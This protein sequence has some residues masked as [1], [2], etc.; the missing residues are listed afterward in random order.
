MRLNEF[1][2]GNKE[3]A[4]TQRLTAST[5]KILAAHIQR[6]QGGGIDVKNPTIFATQIGAWATKFFNSPD[7]VKANGITL[8]NVKPYVQRLVS[9]KLAGLNLNTGQPYPATHPV[10]AVN[11][12]QP[13]QP[14]PANPQNTPNQPTPSVAPVGT[15][16]K[17]NGGN[18]KKTIT[19]WISELGVKIVSP[20]GIKK[21]EEIAEL[22]AAALP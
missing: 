10:S 6:L 9:R 8:N 20:S 21:L 5:L 18:Y 12:A 16:V 19:G 15:V 11:P 1:I 13:N 22:M 3:K 2:F 17:V 14:A 7:E 4:K